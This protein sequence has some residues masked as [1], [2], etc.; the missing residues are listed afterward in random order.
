MATYIN[1]ALAIIEGAIDTT[2]DAAHQQRIA[3]AA[4]KYRPDIL[5]AVAVDPENPTQAEKAEVFVKVVRSWGQSWLRAG[6]EKTTRTDNDAEVEAAGD[7]AA[8]DL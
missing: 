7:A 6:A 2:P 8:G 5:L 3:T 4:I 1:R